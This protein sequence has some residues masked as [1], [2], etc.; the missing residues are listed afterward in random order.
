MT[1]WILRQARLTDTEPLADLASEDGR[2]T[3][4]ASHLPGTAAQEWDLAGRVVLPGLVDAHTH[5]DK[6]YFP[7]Q[8]QSGTLLEAIEL[9]R[10]SKRSRSKAEIQATVRRA[11]ETAIAN[12]ITAMRS[13]VDVE[14]TSDLTTIETLLELRAEWAERIDLQ[15]VALGYPGGTT[16]NRTVMHSAMAMGIDI[17]GGVP[18]LT[19][20][21]HAE[22]DAAFALAEKFGKPLDLHVDET[23]DP[24]M[25][26]LGYL[27]EQTVAHGMQGQVTAGHCC[28]LA[29]AEPATAGRII[30]K[31][32]AAQLTIITLPSCNLV[33]MG[34]GHHCVPRGIT[35]VK[36][37]LARG[38]NVSAASD[39]V[40]D[41]F[42]PFG[43]Y[44]LLQ[45]ANLN[46]HLAHL[47]GTAEIYQSLAMVTT[48]PAQTIGLAD[49]GIAMGQRADLVVL[50]TTS[51]LAAVTTVPPRLATFKAGRLLVRTQS[52]RTWYA[53]G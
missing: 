52:E 42:N 35:R 26:S 33:L 5:L 45:I 46:A 9:W 11:L 37:L 40:H 48:N 22:I 23:E 25:L 20:D 14:A 39:N 32:A 44:D 13:H 7:Q 34:R 41:P 19:A 18:A 10:A 53:N 21:P 49:Y 2:I 8:N 47:S 50:D 17:V 51:C 4:V 15:L 27:A 30:D 16:E 43:S 12:G 3:A 36:E 38:V 29:F 6:T 24:Q 31:V 28:S 1:D